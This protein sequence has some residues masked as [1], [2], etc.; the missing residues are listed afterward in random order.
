MTELHFNFL[1]CDPWITEKKKHSLWAGINNRKNV[2]TS[3]FFEDI[4]YD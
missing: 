2:K 4:Q 3:I 1:V